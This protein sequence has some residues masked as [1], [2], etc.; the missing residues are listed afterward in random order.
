MTKKT[1]NDKP[2]HGFDYVVRRTRR[3]T[4]G[5]YVFRHG[6]VEVRVPLK[7]NSRHINEF[8]E[9]HADW[10]IERLRTLPS[11]R[12]VLQSAFRDGAEHY[13]MGDSLNLHITVDITCQRA[14]IER[15]DQNLQ[16]V[17]PQA[18]SQALVEKILCDWYRQEARQHFAARLQVCLLLFKNMGVQEPS[19]TVRRMRTRWG[20]CSSAGKVNLNLWLM[21]LAP[22]HQ[23]YVITHELAHLLELNHSSRFYAIMDQVMPDWKHRKRALEAHPAS[24]LAS[25]ETMS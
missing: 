17:L 4:L 1:F 5:M 23:D 16:L 25:V 13:F 19:L 18:A 24:C 14:R 2:Q 7:A 21:R 15:A 9:S 3:K 11:E 12:I 20:S 22:E 6:K 10:V 8:V